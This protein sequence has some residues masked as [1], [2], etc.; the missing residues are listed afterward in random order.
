[1]RR[2]RQQGDYRYQKSAPKPEPEPAFAAIQ[3]SRPNS[4]KDIDVVLDDSAHEPGFSL[5]DTGHSFI[6]R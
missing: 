6:L 5:V 2:N 4:M 1:M 3:R